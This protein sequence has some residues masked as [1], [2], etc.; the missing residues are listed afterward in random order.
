MGVRACSELAKAKRSVAQQLDLPKTPQPRG[1]TIPPLNP[2]AAGSPE[3]SRALRQALQ[4]V[5]ARAESLEQD[6]AALNMD[7]LVAEKERDEAHT[8][9]SELSQQL[10]DLRQKGFDLDVKEALRRIAAAEAAAGK[11]REAAESAAAARDAAVAS[12]QEVR[13]SFSVP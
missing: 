11:S 5:T 6:V 8:K 13:P 10:K 7:M 2:A 9:A 4:E 1:L 3:E 12:A